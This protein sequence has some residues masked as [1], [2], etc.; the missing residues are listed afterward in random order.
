M[1]QQPFVAADGA[2][3]VGVSTGG[4]ASLALAARNLPQVEAIV[5]FA[6][7]R[8]GHAY[9]QANAVCGADELLTAARA[10]GAQAREPTIWFYA[11][12]DSYFGP[13]IA[14][15]LAEAWSESGGS[16]EEHILPAYGVDGHTIA[17]D[18]LGWDIWGPSLESF[19][20]RVRENAGG[21]VKVAAD[22]QAQS[23]A[24]L[25]VETSTLQEQA[26]APAQ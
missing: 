7:G 2:V 21:N 22:P 11:N 12:N 13:K 10:Y 18:R 24:A 26:R 6:G 19:L 25:V 3:V 17:D 4:W 20:S 16:V 23:P 8:G 14:K 9:G 1:T 15:G 5:N